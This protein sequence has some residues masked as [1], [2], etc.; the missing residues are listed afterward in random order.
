MTRLK[1]TLNIGVAV[2]LL[3]TSTAPAFA[4]P[5][6]SGPGVQTKARSGRCMRSPM[7]RKSISGWKNPLVG[8]KPVIELKRHTAKKPIGQLPTAARIFMVKDGNYYFPLHNGVFS[9]ITGIRTK[10]LRKYYTEVGTI[11]VPEIAPH[12]DSALGR[13]LGL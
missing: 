5:L 11:K 1:T 12:K 6:A 7:P 4:V 10:D 3:S 13:L 2:A 9:Y 8:K